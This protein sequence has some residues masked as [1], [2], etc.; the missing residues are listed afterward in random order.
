M[1]LMAALGTRAVGYLETPGGLT[2]PDAC[3]IKQITYSFD[4]PDASGSTTVELRK[5]GATIAGTSLPITAANQAGGSGTLTARTVT[6]LGVTMAEG[7]VLNVYVS[8]IGTTPGKGV[9][10]NIKAVTN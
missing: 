8:T 5:N 1:A 10:A 7:D 3:I 4:T 9:T 2:L 6:G